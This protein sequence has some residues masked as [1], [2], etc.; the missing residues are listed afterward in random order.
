MELWTIVN[1]DDVS[2]VEIFLIPLN[3][4]SQTHNHENNNKNNTNKSVSPV[5]NKMM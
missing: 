1:M 3:N 2:G 5:S 4:F